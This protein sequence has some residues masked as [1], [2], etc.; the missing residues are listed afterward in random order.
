MSRPLSLVLHVAGEWAGWAH[1]IMFAA[2]LGNFK[3]EM[4]AIM[5]ELP[6]KDKKKRRGSDAQE[7]KDNIS[8]KKKRKTRVLD[9]KGTSLKAKK[10]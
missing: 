7:M 4:A 6:K 2:E 9:V 8:G 3:E 1:T 10:Q 5:G